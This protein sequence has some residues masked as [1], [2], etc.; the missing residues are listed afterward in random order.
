MVQRVLDTFVPR[1]VC[2]RCER[3]EKTCLCAYIRP[4]ETRTRVLFVQHPREARTAIGTARLAHLC[5]PQSELVVGVH[6]DDDARVRAMISDDARPP[7]LLYPSASAAPLSAFAGS[8]RTLVVID[9]TWPQSKKLLRENPK[10]ASLPR[11]AFTPNAPSDYRIRREPKRDY[12][13]TVES[14]AHA[15]TVLEGNA[16][17]FAPLLDA[18]RAMVDAQIDHELR[19]HSPRAKKPRVKAR[20]ERFFPELVTAS[21]EG[22]VVCVV[23]EANA[24]PYHARKTATHFPDELVQILALRVST[25]E[26]VDVVVKPTNP[27][28]PS[29]LSHTSLSAE[30]LDGGLG[31]EEAR[32]ALARFIREDDL[33]VTWGHYATNLA[34]AA[35]LLP[36]TSIL[37]LRNATK[38]F[39]NGK[40]GTV[41]DLLAK[42][43]L[44]PGPRV[45][46]GRG[47]L[48]LACLTRALTWIAES[49]EAALRPSRRKTNLIR[50][51]EPTTA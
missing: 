7:L 27:L 8:D 48:R 3:P 5:L 49:D 33:V 44:E 14:V 39:V 16:E 15:L 25:N 10:L 51:L 2:S 18:F 45:G 24:W 31:I 40:I 32:V 36:P 42:R 23:V 21:R 46:R 6:V 9:G 22:R 34:A 41:E 13:S 17:R 4:V 20:R 12:V 47:G 11:A 1:M 30:T 19:C 37:C 50:N 35:G 43:E 38:Q 29:T 28:A 26:T